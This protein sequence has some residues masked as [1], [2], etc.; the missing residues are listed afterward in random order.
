MCTLCSSFSIS[1]NIRKP[2]A[3]FYAKIHFPIHTFIHHVLVYTMFFSDLH[4]YNKHTH[5]HSDEHIGYVWCL[6]QVHFDMW[7][8]KSPSARRICF[9]SDYL[10]DISQSFKGD[11]QGTLVNVSITETIQENCLLFQQPLSQFVNQQH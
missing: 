1:L 9:T 8:R 11:I 6:V 5:S 10:C 7:M 3:L 4:L 2:K